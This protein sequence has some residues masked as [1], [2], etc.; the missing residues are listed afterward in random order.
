M[1]SEDDVTIAA[2]FG[3]SQVFW[4]ILWFFLFFLW[5]S[6]V[7]TVFGDIIRSD[8][9]GWGQGP[10]D[11]RH[12]RR[13]LL[14]CVPLPDRQRRKHDPAGRVR[15]AGGGRRS[16]GLHTRRRW[17]RSQP[18]CATGPARRSAR[19]QQAQ[20]RRVR[21]IRGTRPRRPAI[22]R[23][24]THEAP[25]HYHEPLPVGHE[26]PLPTVNGAL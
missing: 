24:V 11:V 7:I 25:A 14:G 9:S 23:R 2:E 12:H 17:H 6:R 10:V 3:T 22:S 1:T 5:I 20:R 21:R 26:R 13:A 4:S 8:M 19:C 15:L 16:G 18:R